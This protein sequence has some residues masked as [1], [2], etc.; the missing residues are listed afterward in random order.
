MVVM[1]IIRKVFPKISTSKGQEISLWLLLPKI[2]IKQ[3]KEK[4]NNNKT[5]F[6][7]YIVNHVCMY[8]CLTYKER[9]QNYHL[10]LV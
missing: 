2:K 1:L 3:N 8:M 4:Q 6:M 9:S 7:L 10:R 5:H